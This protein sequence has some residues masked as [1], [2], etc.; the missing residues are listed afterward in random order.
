MPG[1]LIHKIP[2]GLDSKAAVLAEPL[3]VVL[4][5]LRR[6]QGRLLTGA[7]VAI[8][9]AGQIGHLTAQVLALGGYKVTVFDKNAD[10]LKLLEDKAET[11]QT[12]NNLAKFDF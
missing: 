12:L 9:G 2:A 6:I 7:H 5:A 10:R 3:S 8:V 1:D 4:R 11:S